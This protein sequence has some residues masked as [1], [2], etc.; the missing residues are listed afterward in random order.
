[1]DTKVTKVYAMVMYDG[2]VK[3]AVECPKM[4][5][6]HE[7]SLVITCP[8]DTVLPPRTSLNLEVHKDRFDWWKTRSRATI[9]S[10]E[11]LI[12]RYIEACTSTSNAPALAVKLNRETVAKIMAENGLKPMDL[13]KLADRDGPLI[14]WSDD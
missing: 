1:M 12:E 9:S 6:L 2:T 5:D 14:G 8:R 10:A 7:A 3:R 4:R 11:N 13:S